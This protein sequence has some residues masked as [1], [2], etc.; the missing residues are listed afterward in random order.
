MKQLIGI[1]AAII[2]LFLTA[3]AVSADLIVSRAMFEDKTGTLTIR[4]AATREFTSVSSTL[5]EGYS[6]SAYW[7]RL[8]IKRPAHGNVVV[9]NVGPAFLDDIRL[10]QSIDGKPLEWST[11]VTGDLYPF[12]AR[13]RIDVALGFDVHLTSPEETF[14]LRIKTTSASILSVEALEP[15]AAQRN[16][17]VSGLL[18]HAVM[19][20]MLWAL[21]W[22]I[23][24]FFLD[25]QSTVG[26]FAVYQAVYL[27]FSLSATGELAPFLPAGSI[28]GNWLTDILTWA[29]PFA[30]LIFSRAMLGL[31]APSPVLMRGLNLLLLAFCVPLAA[32]LIGHARIALGL[33]TIMSLAAAW[34]Y[35]IVA[36]GARQQQ[37][38]SR[39]VLLAVYIIIAL[40]TT[41]SVLASLG[42][43]ILAP[44]GIDDELTLIANGLA[45][46]ALIT[47]LLYIR[48][49]R[50]GKD[51]Q[52][53][54]VALALSQH[55]LQE[56][57]R[58][59]EIAQIHAR[60]DYLTGVFNRR[61]FVELVDQEVDRA[62]RHQEP[63]SLMMMDIDHFKSVN[64]NWGHHGGDLVLKRV[65]DIIRETLREVDVLGRMGGEEFAA[66]LVG[67]SGE[68]ALDIAQRIRTAIENAITPMPKGQA[69]RVTL[70][71]GITELRSG[72][73]SLDA[74]IN[75]A[76]QAL[77][78]AKQSGRN[79]VMASD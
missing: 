31:Y 45:A 52:R 2:G 34:Y 28:L 20:M 22:A 57:R 78:R 44:A 9:L 35:V 13:D 68:Q 50:L 59:K 23:D 3:P 8:R 64:D 5:S 49:Q 41:E 53:A 29:V 15:R 7:M 66:L 12:G 32:L 60:T 6:E 17:M 73:L 77:Y 67:T 75:R 16:A 69:V 65:T 79:T 46:S 33:T 30:L 39:R 18:R 43:T 26:L 51:A 21:M 36:L 37:A 14:Y 76:D 27:L 58:H 24:H 1:I 25:R 40:L 56:E 70:S 71:L 48:L 74:L 54:A 10:Y 47:M 19:G 42:W 62:V 72:D 61:H 38:P 55:A 11:R 4:E 63:L